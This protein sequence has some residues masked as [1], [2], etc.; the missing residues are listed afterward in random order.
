M[1][2][3]LGRIYF[4]VGR[5]DLQ[6]AAG[7]SL[8]AVGSVKLVVVAG[9][10]SVEQNAGNGSDG[11]TGQVDVNACDGKADAAHR[12]EAQ[13]AHQNDSGH[14]QVAAVGKVHPV[15]HHIADTDGGDHAV[16]HKADA[17]D[18]AGGDGV[19]DGLKLGAEA[20]DDG[21]DGGNADDQ[22]VVDLAQGQHAGVLAVGGVGRAAQQA[23]H[24]GGQTVA[25]QG[26]VQAGVIDIVVADG[27][28]DGGD[29]AHML[30]HGS[31]CDGDDGEQSADEFRAAVDGEQTH[32]LLVQG[33][34]EPCRVGDLLEVHGTGDQSH[35]VGHQHTDQDGQDLDHALTPDVADNDHAQRHKGQQPVGLAVFDGRGS[36]DQTDG[37]DDGAGDHRGEE[38]HDAAD[39]EGGD[40]QAGHQVHQAGE[41]NGGAG[42]GQHLGVDHGQVAVSVCQHGGHDGKAAQVSKGGAQ[43]SRDLLFGDQMEQQ[44]AQTSAQQRGGNAQAGEQR[45]QHRGTKHSKHVLHTQDQH[46]SGAQLSSV[47]YALGVID[48]FTHG[49]VYLLRQPKKRGIAVVN[50][51]AS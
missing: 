16:E 41:G 10:D 48:L 26:A 36:Q 21:H 22:R 28:A 34:A 45:H 4:I 12:V 33:D 50:G 42:V 51:S 24:G 8:G 46:P 32:G 47:V 30:H 2:G 23:G 44:R 13:G 15:L 9:Q 29:I 35:R 39:A 6:V 38:P 37:D 49:F 3:F 27:S 40:Q 1:P 5:S 25:Q 18:N 20:Q 11:Q 19:D 17:A 43:E 7:S 31:Q 14:D